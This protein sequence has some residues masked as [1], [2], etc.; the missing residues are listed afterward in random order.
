M[1]WEYGLSGQLEALAYFRH[2]VLG[3]RLVECVTA[4]LTH[5]DRDATA[6]LGAIDAMK[7]RSFLTLFATVAPGEPCFSAA[8][9]AFYRGAPDHE[10][11][12]LLGFAPS[13]ARGDAGHLQ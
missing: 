9:E 5:A 12:K 13:V 2:P 1:A 10:T 11:L 8:L 7:F 3:P 4:M 6:I